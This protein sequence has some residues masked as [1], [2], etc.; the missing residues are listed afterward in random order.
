M[1]PHSPIVPF[2]Y[3]LRPSPRCGFPGLVQH[4]TNTRTAAGNMSSAVPLAT[5]VII[6]SHADQ[7]T[8][9]LAHELRIQ[10][11]RIAI[12]DGRG[13][14]A[15]RLGGRV[16]WL[17]AVAPPAYTVGVVQAHLPSRPSC[18]LGRRAAGPSS[19]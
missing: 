11:A 10:T 2:A 4:L 9:L 8:N 1:R 6:G 5:I 15:P 17:V 3:L 12:L 7:G 18:G 19:R 14:G 13:D 16:G